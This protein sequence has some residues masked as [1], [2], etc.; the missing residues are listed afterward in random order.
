MKGEWHAVEMISRFNVEQMVIVSLMNTRRTPLWK[1]A[2]PRA[3][4]VA[5]IIAEAKIKMPAVSVSMGCARERG[6]LEMELLAIG[7][8]INR[9]ALP[10]EEAVKRA[11][12]HGLQIRYQKTCCSLP[13]SFSCETWQ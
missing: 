10:S 12:T 7:A 13:G 4:E 9:M 1:V 8:G 5:E 11:E 3:E 6:N 2:S